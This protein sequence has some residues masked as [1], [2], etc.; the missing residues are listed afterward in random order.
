MPAAGRLG[1]S[2]YTRAEVS[3]AFVTKAWS[4][5][6]RGELLEAVG[7]L[8]RGLLNQP[9]DL[10]GRLVLGAALV[11]LG[12]F[13]QAASEMRIALDLDPNSAAA[14]AVWGEA[15]LRGGDKAGAAEI[16]RR[17]LTLEPTDETIAALLREATAGEPAAAPEGAPPNL[18]RSEAGAGRGPLP[19]KRYPISQPPG[20]VRT[21]EGAR[22]TLLG[23][24]PRAGDEGRLTKPHDVRTTLRVLDAQSA[25]AGADG[26]GAA[27]VGAPEESPTLTFDRGGG[28]DERPTLGY[29]RGGEG[30]E[31]PTLTFDRGE[32]AEERPTVRHDDGQG[33]GEGSPTIR[34]DVEADAEG[35]PT[36][37][38]DAR[39]EDSSTL[40]YGGASTM[41]FEVIAPLIT[42]AK[43]A[44]GRLEVAF[45]CPVTGYV[46][47]SWADLQPVSS[48]GAERSGMAR[49]VRGLGANV[50]PVFQPDD[51]PRGGLGAA[52][53]RDAAIAAFKR[54]S[55]RFRWDPTHRGFVHRSA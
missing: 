48:S 14:L 25:S 35:S 17:A 37:R 36:I 6:D 10:E 3:S 21:D 5:L 46:V 30:E 22:A 53:K 47:T 20:G 43:E 18:P 41:L 49:A 33:G 27:V 13:Q 54:V 42:A 29:E 26:A 9:K 51:G 34:D 8:R 12:R 2:W 23:W 40:R 1:I 28:G 32:K 39:G 38:D 19:T 31:R 15:L 50:R 44:G 16:F 24:A 7:E 11:A 4:L 52:E 55:D 45:S